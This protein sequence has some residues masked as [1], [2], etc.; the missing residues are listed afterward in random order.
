ML[1]L[2]VGVRRVEDLF[3]EAVARLFE[4]RQDL[5]LGWLE[6]IGVI[7]PERDGMYRFVQRVST[8][9]SFVAHDDHETGSRPDMIVE[10]GYAPA[11]DSEPYTEVVMIES[12]IGSLE[13]QDQL[14][15]YAS[16]LERLSSEKKTLIYITRAYD[17]KVGAEILAGTDGVDFLQLRW[18]DF[19]RFLQDIEKDTL[20]EELML[21]M[22]ERGMSRSHRISAADL[23]A[24]SGVPR[25]FEIFD[26]VLGDDVIHELGSFAGNKA[27]IY[28]PRSQVRSLRRYIA[29][30]KLHNLDLFCFVGFHSSD[31][32]DYSKAI[33]QLES[34][35]RALKKDV[36][37]KAMKQIEGSNGWGSYGINDLSAWSGIYRHRSLSSFLH[38]EDHIAAI[39]GFFIESIHQ[40]RDELTEFK[41]ENPELPWNGGS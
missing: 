18:H 39:K 16:H 26:E 3:T 36:S 24:L 12:K 37:L 25:A 14:R 38:E 5:C 31:S 17:P 19:Y 33:V 32:E 7:S 35:P 10:I 34:R 30:G 40:L 2:F 1:P 22:E 15:R 21:F 4:L 29:L 13:G 28:Q 8:Q 27:G 20:I 41:R 23:I 9:K 11:D 6:E